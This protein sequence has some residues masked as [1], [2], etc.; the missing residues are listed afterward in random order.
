MDALWR[1]HILD[2]LQLVDLLPA[3]CASAVDLG[4]GAGFPGLVLAIATGLVFDL[5]ESDKRKS[6]FLTY[7]AQLTSAPVRVHPCRIE[8]CGISGAD[9]VTSRAL[10]PLTQLLDYAAPLLAPRG[11]CL[12]PKGE[13]A[14]A[15]IADAATIWR[16]QV[17]RVPSRVSE[18]GEVLCISEVSRV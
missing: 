15:E 14:S 4:S 2:S 1:R 13:N 18:R 17:R 3:G 8:E 12:L 16:M 9:V 11:V 7:A 10:A 5:V 6:A